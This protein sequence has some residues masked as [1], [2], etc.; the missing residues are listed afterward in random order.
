MVE[1]S[2]TGRL[3]EGDEPRRPQHV[4]HALSAVLREQAFQAKRVPA[5]RL[6]KQTCAKR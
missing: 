4:E 2:A 1:V 6:L 3:T 5:F